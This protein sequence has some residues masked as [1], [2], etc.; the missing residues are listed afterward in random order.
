MQIL[1][2]LI[3]LSLAAAVLV[4]RHMGRKYAFV[5][6]RAQTC[7]GC[8]KI[9]H[10]AIFWNGETSHGICSAMR[11]AK[12]KCNRKDGVLSSVTVIGHFARTVSV[13]EIQDY[14][15][16]KEGDWEKAKAVI[17]APPLC[18]YPG[19]GIIVARMYYGSENDAATDCHPITQAQWDAKHKD[20]KGTRIVEATATAAR[21]RVR[22][23]QFSIPG[24]NNS[25]RYRPVYITDAKIKMPPKADAVPTPKP[26]LPEKHLPQPP[27]LPVAKPIT[28]PI[29]N[30]CP[31]GPACADPVCQEERRKIGIVPRRINSRS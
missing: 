27:A 11:A 20:Y 21:H 24:D 22:Y 29:D 15:A 5:A 26:Q 3:I 12:C 8:H 30:I 23:G 6:L 13:D 19:Q 31:D 1:I 10:Y 2:P 9:K 14:R 28:P 17:T 18:N 7:A 4:V 16:P 25:W